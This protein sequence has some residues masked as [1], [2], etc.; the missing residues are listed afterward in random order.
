MTWGAAVAWMGHALDFYSQHD[1]LANLTLTILII[2]GAFALRRF[3]LSILPP[4]LSLDAR[5]K[6]VV[7][8]RNGIGATVVVLIIMLWSTELKTLIVS[9]IA[10]AA[11]VVLATKEVIMSMLGSIL[12]TTTQRYK[13]G[14]RLE[15]RDFKGDV[16]DITWLSTMLMELNPTPGVQMYTGKVIFIPNSLILTETLRVHHTTSSYIVHTFSL[17]INSLQNPAMEQH[18]LQAICMR[19]CAPY[20]ADAERHY[21]TIKEH[22]AIDMPSTLPKTLIHSDSGGDWWLTSRMVVPIKTVQAMEQEIISTFLLEAPKPL[23]PALDKP[24][25]NW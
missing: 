20:I 2:F 13:I 6:K 21:Q 25:A 1:V 3:W 19:V 9:L 23:V 10:I 16:V 11:A 24:S 4:G 7:G 12:R 17:P 14:D 22:T 8:I 18:R 5:R 15:V